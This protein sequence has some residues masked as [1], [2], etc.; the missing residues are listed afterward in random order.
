MQFSSWEQYVVFGHRWSNN[1]ILVKPE[2]ITASDVNVIYYH[3]LFERTYYQN[4]DS[5]YVKFA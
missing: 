5:V 3:Y 4:I 2:F 1:E